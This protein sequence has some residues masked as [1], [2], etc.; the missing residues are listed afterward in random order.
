MRSA[1]LLKIFEKTG[2]NQ[3]SRNL[4]ATSGTPDTTD[5]KR[6][7]VFTINPRIPIYY[8]VMVKPESIAAQVD[9]WEGLSQQDVIYLPGGFLESRSTDL[10]IHGSY[11]F[12][13][14]RF[15]GSIF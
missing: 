3:A 14:D 10:C 5:Y 9:G 15:I 4:L 11:L 13:Y 8:R 6:Y 1:G 12:K 2:L 7:H